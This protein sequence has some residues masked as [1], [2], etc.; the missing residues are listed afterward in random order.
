VEAVFVGKAGFEIGEKVYLSEKLILR[1][2]DLQST[3]KFPNWPI[4]QMQKGLNKK[5]YPY[6]TNSFPDIS[7]T[8]LKIQ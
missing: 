3:K 2:S 4:G 1:F 8:F 7:L 6:D 5:S